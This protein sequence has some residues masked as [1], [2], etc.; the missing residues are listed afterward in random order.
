MITQRLNDVPDRGSQI[1]SRVVLAITIA[2][3]CALFI[4]MA[5]K[6]P[7]ILGGMI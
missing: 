6:Y 3:M 4:G 2:V 5:V 7:G 1:I